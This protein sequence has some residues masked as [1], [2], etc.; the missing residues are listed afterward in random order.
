MEVMWKWLLAGVYLLFGMFVLAVTLWKANQAASLPGY[1]QQVKGAATI[2]LT[3]DV[4]QDPLL[5]QIWAQQLWWRLADDPLE[6]SKRLLQLSGWRLQTACQLARQGR[7]QAAVRQL[8]R[9]TVYQAKARQIASRLP[10]GQQRV[11][12]SVWQQHMQWQRGQLNLVI[13]QLPSP[14]R[15]ILMHWKDSQAIE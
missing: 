7:V 11:W 10:I 14:E 9:A 15:E 13:N 3:T 1:N 6:Q 5:S 4:S 12:Q 2:S 8:N